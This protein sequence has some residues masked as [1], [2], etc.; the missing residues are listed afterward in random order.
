[1]SVYYLLVN[2]TKITLIT[3]EDDI[4]NRISVKNTEIQQIKE[5]NLYKYS[6]V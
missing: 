6:K 5:V 3:E 4:I 2:K 1:M